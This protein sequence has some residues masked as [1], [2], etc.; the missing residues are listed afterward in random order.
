PGPMRCPG[1]ARYAPRAGPEPVHGAVEALAARMF[2]PGVAVAACPVEPSRTPDWPVEAA[3][4]ALAVPRRRA[5][6]AAGRLA[7]RAAMARL[8]MPAM[9]IP[10]GADRAPVW[11]EGLAGSI[12]HTGGLALAAVAMR[13]EVRSIG[14]DA[15]PDEAMPGA[16]TDVIC[17]AAERRWCAGQADP[18]RAA[19]AIFVAK[20]AVYKAQFPLSRTVF[21]FEVI[22]IA[23][24]PDGNR[25]EARFVTPVAPFG[26]GTVVSGHLCRAAGMVLAAVTLRSRSED[27]G[28]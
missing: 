1:A 14:I 19:R 28:G 27:G 8:G 25:F 3:G 18:A 12:T 24:S 16:V 7:A 20:E 21:G 17:R 26:Q 4:V 22:E 9:P 13:R 23:V 5:E 10:M 6:F 15:E 2:P 11:P